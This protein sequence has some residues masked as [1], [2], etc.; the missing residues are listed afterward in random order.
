MTSLLDGDS[1]DQVTLAELHQRAEVGYGVSLMI[2]PLRKTGNSGIEYLVLQVDFVFHADRLMY[3]NCP[4][5][6]HF[7][8]LFT[9][10]DLDLAMKEALLGWE[11]WLNEWM[12][13][14]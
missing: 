1:I 9:I 2:S 12:R 6:E 10:E 11:N 3:N 8:S 7:H 13:L 5:Y 14:A 4:A